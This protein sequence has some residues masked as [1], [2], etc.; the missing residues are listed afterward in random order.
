M[1]P[2]DIRIFRR[3]LPF[4]VKEVEESYSLETDQDLQTLATAI[5]DKYNQPRPEGTE[6]VKDTLARLEVAIRQ[7]DRVQHAR[8]FEGF[9]ERCSAVVVCVGFGIAK[10]F[11]ECE[12]ER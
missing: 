11:H 7:D 3:E 2:Y 6:P 9:A 10:P 4:L 8:P 5:A 1:L 12:S